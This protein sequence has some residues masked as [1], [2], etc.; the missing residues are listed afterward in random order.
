MKYFIVIAYFFCYC[1]AG[2]EANNALKNNS[3]KANF[4][5]K[6]IEAYE[7]NSFS[8]VKDFY[9]YLEIYADE[10][11]SDA[12]KSQVQEN[13]YALFN[14]NV[15]VSGFFNQDKITLD[16]LLER[17]KSKGLKFTVKDIQKETTS[18]NFWT[19]SYTLEITGKNKTE[20]K[21]IKQKIY[22]YP[23]EKSFGDKK[24]EVWQ[25]FLGE[26]N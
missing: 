18:S 20:Q 9:E 19:T 22:F 14:N 2:Q 26:I 15:T 1:V 6:I 13:I 10:D 23:E 24:K 4:S 21:K 3:I 12:L 11:A 8:K 16:Q 5:M 7:E 17:I 25:L